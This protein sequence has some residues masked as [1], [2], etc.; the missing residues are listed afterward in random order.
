MR[1][2]V[3]LRRTVIGRRMPKLLASSRA[4]GVRGEARVFG[5]MGR[6]AVSTPR[7]SRCSK[8]G[9]GVVLSPVTHTA[10]PSSRGS[11]AVSGP[12]PAGGDLAATPF[13]SVHREG[14]PVRPVRA[15]RCRVRGPR[16]KARPG[17]WGPQPRG[18]PP[19]E[20][21]RLPS[22]DQRGSGG[23]VLGGP[24]ECEQENGAPPAVAAVCTFREARTCRQ[25][26]P[27]LSTQQCGGFTGSS[28]PLCS[29]SGWHVVG[30]PCGART[31]VSP[32]R[33]AFARAGR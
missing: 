24:R 3:R 21:C 27:R 13:P 28:R 20:S 4:G 9:C 30:T 26:P 22:S 29:R 6:G 10:L 16:G 23:V 1:L 25:T 19:T 7:P 31:P 11:L 17:V 8:V 32:T 12:P 5:C 2:T 15:G 33:T 14:G 18:S